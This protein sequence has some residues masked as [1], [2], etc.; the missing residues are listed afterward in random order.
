ML[1]SG[2]R[3]RRLRYGKGR[4]QG[5]LETVTVYLSTSRVIIST[6]EQSISWILAMNNVCLR[7]PLGAISLRILWLFFHTMTCC[8]SLRQNHTLIWN[9][10]LWESLDEKAWITCMWCLC[11]GEKAVSMMLGLSWRGSHPLSAHILKCISHPINRAGGKTQHMIY[12]CLMNMSRGGGAGYVCVSVYG[13][14]WL[15]FRVCVHVCLSVRLCVLVCVC[16]CSGAG[17]SLGRTRLLR[18]SCGVLDTGPI[19][20]RG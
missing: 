6:M 7:W 12:C 14:G 20:T 4:V 19:V 8:C 16:V 13:R 1:S 9:A 15:L 5:W 10:L 17:C 11:F 3:E 2:T 18:Y